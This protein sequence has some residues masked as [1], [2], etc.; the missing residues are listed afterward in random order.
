MLSE[1]GCDAGVL[2]QN[3]RSILSAFLL[4]ALGQRRVFD[5]ENFRSQ[6]SGV[7]SVVDSDGC[8]RNPGGHLNSTEQRIHPVQNGTFA[9]NADDR[10]SGVRRNGAC[11]MGC[12]TGGCQKNAETV[13]TGR[14]GKLPSL[15]RGPVCRIDMHFCLC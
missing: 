10:K 7:G 13:L 3:C 6:Q 15:F 12:H 8:N 9:G 1:A 14:Y 2:F 11:E 5:R 4:Q